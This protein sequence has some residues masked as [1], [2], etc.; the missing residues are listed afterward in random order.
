MIEV[1][2]ILVA[3]LVWLAAFS[4]IYG[5]HGIGCAMGWGEVEVLW[6]S[7]FRLLLL[8]AWLVAIVAEIGIL[9]L[10]RSERF[11]SHQSFVR[12]ASVATGWVGLVATLWTLYPVTL[13]SAC[14]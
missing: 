1:L 12:S 4:G 6:L 11:G 7:L 5:L 8:A 14:R 2:R 10:L 3:P 9:M 13:M